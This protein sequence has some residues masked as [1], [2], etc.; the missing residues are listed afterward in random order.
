[1]LEQIVRCIIE[2]SNTL[3]LI[4]LYVSSKCLS[5]DGMLRSVLKEHLQD[6]DIGD[7]VIRNI[8]VSCLIDCCA[9]HYQRSSL[10]ELYQIAHSNQCAAPFTSLLEVFCGGK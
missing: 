7:N 1:M 2:L 8:C 10:G 3:D 6:G 4:T 5:R 9:Y